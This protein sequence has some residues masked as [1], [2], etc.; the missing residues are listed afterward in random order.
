ME[1][2]SLKKHRFFTVSI[3]FFLSLVFAESKDFADTPKILRQL[4]DSKETASFRRWL[5]DMDK[6]SSLPKFTRE[7]R[8]VE[9][10]AQSMLE[11]FGAGDFGSTLQVGISPSLKG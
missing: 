4:R 5:T 7:Y 1:G 9:A 10:L 2:N 3:P 11:G 6:E 8:E